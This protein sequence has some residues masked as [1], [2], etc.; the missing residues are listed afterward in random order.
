TKCFSIAL[1]YLF[2]IFYIVFFRDR[3]NEDFTEQYG[4]EKATV[5]TTRVLFYFRANL[6][7]LAMCHHLDPQIQQSVIN[8]GT[9]E[10]THILIYD[11]V[12]IMPKLHGHNSDSMTGLYVL[13]VR[14]TKNL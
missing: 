6:F 4:G 14:Y 12:N 13:S 11:E 10:L 7:M 8:E 2:F 3:V 1:N 9:K 5:A